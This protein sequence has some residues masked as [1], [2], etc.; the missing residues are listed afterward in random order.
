VTPSRCSAPL[1]LAELL[2][3][4]LD[5]LPDG[6]ASDVEAH[7]F[8]CGDCSGRLESIAALGDGIRQIVN[9][10]GVVAVFPPVFLGRLKQAGVQ[11]REYRMGP[12]EGVYC[13][14]APQDDLVAA[15]LRVPLEDVRRLDVLM[16]DPAAEQTRRLADVP[17]D[18][19]AGEIV[20]APRSEDLRH[21]GKVVQR[22][23]LVAVEDGAE[24]ML[25]A[26]TFNHT[27]WGTG[28]PGPR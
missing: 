6:S 14:I 8:G 17:F 13:T 19:A 27:P 9:T 1:A 25:G 12:N 28:G 11:V 2:E 3:Y 23:E 20:L 26:Y 7:V 24:R 18:P 4:W 10:G 5:D 16:H 22:V 15:H 21:L